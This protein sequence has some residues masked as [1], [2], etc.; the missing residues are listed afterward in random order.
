MKH[1]PNILSCIRAVLAVAVLVLMIL[2]APLN[3]YLLFLFC[4]GLLFLIGSITDTL[5]GMIARKK[6]LVSD[7]GKFI[8][9]IADKILTTF[10]MLGFLFIDAD[11]GGYVLLISIAVTLLREFAIASLRMMAA[12]NGTV[13]AADWAGKIKTV[14]Q[15]VAIGGYYFCFNTPYLFIAQILMTAA[16]VMTIVSGSLYIKN[17]FKVA[18]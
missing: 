6:N 2:L 16:T 15:M 13:I 5:D 9:P 17:Y 12:K 7:F 4:P 11:K 10:A 1:L 3:N 18:K 14:L 8:D